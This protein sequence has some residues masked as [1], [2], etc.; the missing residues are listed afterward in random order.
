MLNNGRAGD[1][2]R[3]TCL[4]NQNGVHFINDSEVVTTLHLSVLAGGHAVVAQVV[5]TE[6]G[7]GSVGDILSILAAAQV[8]GHHALD[9]ADGKAEEGEQSTHPHGVTAGKVI[10]HR[11]H[12]HTH[13]GKSIQIHRQGCHQGLTFTRGHFGNETTMQ[14]NTT[15][16]LHIEM[17]HIP[18]DG[19]A[20]HIHHLATQQAGTTLHHSKGFRENGFQILGAQLGKLRLDFR[21]SLL[22]SLNGFRRSLHLG[23]FGELRSQGFKTG[24]ELSG[25]LLQ[26]S[27]RSGQHNATGGQI[28]GSK[29]VQVSLP[30]AS[31]TN[32]EI[33]VLISPAFLQIQ[34]TTHNRLKLTHFALVLGTYDFVQNPLNHIRKLSGN[35]K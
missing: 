10:I 7:I 8:A 13:A 30:L 18:L 12:M 3:G 2:E 21:Q 14:R 28:H 25:I 22:T 11:H 31:L 17:H 4:V 24:V 35:K 6:F 33:A 20:A 5:E 15:D 34:N 19:R 9:A 29:A 1:D 26:L 16:E 23:Q 32:Q 27:G